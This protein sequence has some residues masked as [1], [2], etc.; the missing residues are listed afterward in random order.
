LPHVV[1]GGSTNTSGSEHRGDIDGLR[2]VAV[3]VV[4]GF[5]AG[6][7]GLGAGFIGVDVF[8]VISGFLIMGLLLREQQH[9]GRIDLGRFW[10]RRARRLMPALTV[11]ILVTLLASPLL[12]VALQWR[13]V[14]VDSM[15]S[16]LYVSNISFALGTR[17]YFVESAAPPPFLHTWSLAVEEQFYIVWPL[18]M[19]FMIWAATRLHRTLLSV[20]SVAVPSIVALSF[21]LSA[22]MSFRGS[23][24][25][26]YSL[27][28]RWW[29]IGLA[30]PSR[31]VGF[32]GGGGVHHVVGPSA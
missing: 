21:A 28:T 3:A 18:A 25:S 20:L 2:A 26:Y 1:A 14:A 29:E 11:M 32:E 22:L 12:L 9:S 5:H 6:I 27:P 10:A 13:A 19:S 31:V 8:F 4:V 7:P 16:S 15:W 30:V 17:G 23:R 24:W